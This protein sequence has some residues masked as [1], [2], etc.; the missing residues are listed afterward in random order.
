MKRLVLLSLLLFLW[1]PSLSDAQW[2]NEPVGSTLITECGFPLSSC[3]G[4]Y[5]GYGTP[6]ASDGAEP[7]SPPTVADFALPY[8]GPCPTN[9]GVYQSCANGGGQFGYQH[10]AATRE[11]YVGQYMKLSDGYGCSSVG[12]SKTFFIRT[13]DNTFGGPRI[14][15]VFLVAGCGSTKT[16]IFS[17]NTGDQP[18]YPALHN[19]HACPEDPFN[20]LTCRQNVSLSG[21]Q[22]G[23]WVK[24]EACIRAST[25]MTSRDAVLRLWI[26]GTEVMRYTNL[27][28][29]QGVMNQVD[30]TPTWDGYGNGQGFTMTVHQYYGHFRISAPPSGGCAASIGGSTPNPD[31]PAGPPA[32][33][34]GLNAQKVVS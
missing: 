11:L 34:T 13:F 18:G 26:N 20:G 31:T 8:A 25:T 2:V 27:N 22:T 29:G 3:P 33:P 4:W 28:Y 21:F 1:M 12:M 19:E 10:N 17:H 24:V 7:K 15:G 6:Y 5:D 23:Q 14:N 16:W 32:A 9:P 30:A